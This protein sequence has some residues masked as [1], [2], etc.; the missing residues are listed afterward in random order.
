MDADTALDLL[1]GPQVDA[2]VDAQ[3]FTDR[4]PAPQDAGVALNVNDVQG[5]PVF[6]TVLTKKGKA[7]EG[8]CPS[9][10][11]LGPCTFYKLPTPPK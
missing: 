3:P 7:W 5:G 11:P 1:E 9:T 4:G 6:I 10:L 8:T 2:L